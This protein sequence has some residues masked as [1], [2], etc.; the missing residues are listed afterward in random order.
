VNTIPP[1]CAT[2]VHAHPD[3]EEICLILSGFGEYPGSDGRAVPVG[4]GDFAMIR[5]GESHG[6]RNSREVPLAFAAVTV[7]GPDS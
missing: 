3:Y 1:G 7:A 4:S 6:L 5:R 2:G